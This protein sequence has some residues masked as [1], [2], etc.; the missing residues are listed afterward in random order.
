MGYTYLVLDNTSGAIRILVLRPVKRLDAPIS[1][2]LQHVSHG[3]YRYTAVSYIW[4]DPSHTHRIQISGRVF[5]FAGNFFNVLY[6]SRDQAEPISLW[7]D[8]IYI[9]HN[10]VKERDA[11]VQKWPQFT[12]VHSK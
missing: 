9:D 10:I 4:G 1:G 5:G 7:I 12:V 11:Q 8:A 6:N 3:S 2:E